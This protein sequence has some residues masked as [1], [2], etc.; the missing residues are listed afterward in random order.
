MKKVYLE[1][2][3]CQ[4]NVS[5]SER[6]A[7]QMSADGYEITSDETLADVVLL[8]TCSVREKAEHKLFTRIGQIRKSAADRRA[9]K[10]MLGILG[11]VAQLEGE[12]LFS[13]SPA[14]DFVLG[15]KAVGRVAVAVA[16][17]LDGQSFYTD[18]GEREES[19]E[20]SVAAA[21][22]NSPYIA[23]VP[24]IEGCNKFCTYCIVPFSR[25]REKSLSASEIV[26]H[27]R[28][29]RSEGIREVHLIGQNVNSYRPPTD[30]GLEPFRGATQFSRLLRAVAATG[31]ERVKFTTS[32]PRDFHPDIVEALNENVNLCNWVHL[33]V[34]SGSNRI[35]KLM[36]RGHTIENYLER[37]AKI[38]ASP[39]RISLT[40][41]IIVGFP[42]ETDADFQATLNLTEQCKFSSA[43][44][45]KYSPRPGTPA[46]AMSDDVPAQEKTARF[47]ELEKLIRV[48][49]QKVFQSYIGRTVEVLAEKVSDKH[50]A[51]L[52]GH[53]TC[54]MVVNFNGSAEMCGKIVK[55]QI[56]ESKVNTLYGKIC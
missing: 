21:Q 43:Y 51:Q 42:G 39:R 19:Y 34:Q 29:L 3:G 50:P 18:L 2:F 8:N 56:L 20:W 54:Q 38:Q 41:D 16:E 26:R 15:T 37:I 1:T 44:I 36:R 32:F 14:I 24:I 11:C 6:V 49:Q 28:H 25:G 4:M 55:V 46:F 22:R 9:A 40:T 13:K 53:S 7:T 10:P 33:P 35:L 23:F 52:S 27:I 31:I 48:Q 30:A 47:L 17:V 5:D 45:F 12:T